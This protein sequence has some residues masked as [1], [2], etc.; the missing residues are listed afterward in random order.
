M[1]LFGLA[2]SFAR[3]FLVYVYKKRAIQAQKNC[4]VTRK[5]PQKLN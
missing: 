5:R 2:Y 3:A 4:G 1:C